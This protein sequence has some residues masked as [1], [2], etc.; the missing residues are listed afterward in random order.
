[1]GSLSYD[2]QFSTGLYNIKLMKFLIYR[3]NFT[4]DKLSEQKVFGAARFSLDDFR[5][6]SISWTLGFKHPSILVMSV[7]KTS[8]S[9]SIHVILAAIWGCTTMTNKYNS[10]VSFHGVM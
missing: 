6:S 9:R 4:D 3:E 1:M 7:S 10:N 5:T 8:N 2:F